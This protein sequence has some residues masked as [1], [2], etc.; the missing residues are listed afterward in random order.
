M[1]VEEDEFSLHYSNNYRDI[2]LTPHEEI[3]IVYEDHQII[4][5][6][7]RNPF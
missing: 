3:A 7:P 1:P 4:G 2:K 5:L 6:S